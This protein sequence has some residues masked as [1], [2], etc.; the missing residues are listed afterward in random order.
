[1]IASTTA[2]SPAHKL[3][4]ER[5]LQRPGA[6]ERRA[7]AAARLRA[8]IVEAIRRDQPGP[9]QAASRIDPDHAQVPRRGLTPA[10]QHHLE[11]ARRLDPAHAQAA[12][13]GEMRSA[14]DRLAV[15]T[16]AVAP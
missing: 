6:A 5:D 11:R 12:L 2:G 10:V 15:E 4:R 8:Q 13:A 16:A 3:V 7:E 14:A 1:A 9:R